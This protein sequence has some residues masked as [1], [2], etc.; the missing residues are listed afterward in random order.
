MMKALPRVAY[1]D[2]EYFFDERLSEL[3]EVY[4]PWM[5]IPLKDY[6]VWLI[7]HTKRCP[8]ELSYA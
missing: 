3:R 5:R 2:C 7:K 6:E 1:M 8:D 4:R